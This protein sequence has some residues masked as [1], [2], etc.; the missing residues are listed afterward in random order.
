[1]LRKKVTIETQELRFNTGI[2]AMMEFLNT[3]QKWEAQP[4]SVLKDFCLLLSPYAPHIAEELWEMLCGAGG[5]SIAYQM[6]PE[7]DEKLLVADV[8]KMVVQVNGKVRGTMEVEPGIEKDAALE[9]ANELE[10]VKKFVDGKE[11]K[12][13]IFVPGK[14]VNIVVGK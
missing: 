9:M 10:N 8:V 1:M 5:E 6:W 7:V 11:V 12:K 13:M 2:A 14:I 3:A 4:K